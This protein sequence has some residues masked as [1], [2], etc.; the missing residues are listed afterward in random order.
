MPPT[1]DEIHF[2]SGFTGG[3]V[4]VTL[5]HLLDILRI[6][7]SVHDTKSIRP[8]YHGYWHTAECIVKAEGLKGLY[9]GFSPNVISGAL[10]WGL[11]FSLYHKMHPYFNFLS[12][13]PGFHNLITGFV[14][15]S[16]YEGQRKQYHGLIHVLTTILKEDGIKG[17]YKGYLP[18]LFGAVHGSIQF[19]VYNHLKDYRCRI[20]N[21]PKD[22]KLSTRDYLIF[23]SLSKVLA[24]ALMYP[25]E[26]VK[27]RLQDHHTDYESL[28]DVM[29]KTFQNEGIPGFYKGML[30]TILKQLPKAVV[31]Y[32]VYEQTRYFVK[33]YCPN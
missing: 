13:K 22:S 11:Y 1:K 27:A 4:A 10:S 32:V 26:V 24:T 21:I 33:H 3:L 16:T 23:S 8:Q 15:G 29:S 14:A 17:W 28:R 7:H 12:D 18:S 5:F 30:I 20:L 2:I 19:A 9:Q 25:H 31:V 6:R